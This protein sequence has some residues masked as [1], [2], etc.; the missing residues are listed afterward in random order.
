MSEPITIRKLIERITLGDIR[1]PAFQRDF[2]WEPEQVAFLLDSIYKGFPIGTIILWK[3]DNRLATE[4]NLGRFKLPEPQRD[5]PVNYV[6]DGQ[7]RITSLFSVFQTELTPIENNWIDIYFDI[8]AEE[9]IQ[10]SLFLPL[11]NNEVDLNRHFPV[12]VFFDTVAYRKA[13]STLNDDIVVKIDKLQEKFKEY[14]IPNEI[15]ES[16]NR[17]NVAI[18]FERI[19]RAGTELDVFQLLSAWSWSDDFDLTE[20]FADLQEEIVEH[21]FDELCN[22]R[23]LQLRICAGIIKG[24]TTP[25]KILEMQG[26]EIRQNFERIRRGIIG[27]IDFLKRELNVKNFKLLPF[28]GTLVPLC[29]FFATNKVEGQPYTDQQKDKLTKWFWRSI[30][31]RR[32]SAGVNEKQANDIREILKLKD[33]ED[34]PFDFINNEVKFDFKSS[35]FSI[36]NANSRSLILLL[37]TLNP[38]SLLSGARIDLDKILQKVNKNEFHHI[39]PQKYLKDQ[40]FTTKQI[41]VLANICFLTRGDNNKIKDK[42][43]SEY[44]NDIPV[45]KKNDYLGR[46][47]LPEDITEI[48]YQEFLDKRATLLENKAIEL[49][50]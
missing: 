28:P 27:A 39:F 21:G 32:F 33:N 8:M 25:A 22:N 11:E 4:K 37:S 34:Y 24:E 38:F 35:N 49:M 31:T 16:D 41:N 1:I 20:K 48:D 36:A 46:A 40:G 15:F 14:L 29:C 10:E 50:A 12:N 18:V 44:I 26:E 43:P 23:D 5:Y 3:T 2:V 19:N 7:Q 30:F 42:S 45:E 47:L 17:N 9:N 13:T 6:L